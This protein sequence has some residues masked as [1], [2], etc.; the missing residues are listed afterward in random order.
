M[1]ASKSIVRENVGEEGVGSTVRRGLVGAAGGTAVEPD[2]RYVRRRPQVEPPVIGRHVGE[3]QGMGGDR[4][5][6]GRHGQAAQAAE[7][8]FAGSRL[9]PDDA[10]GPGR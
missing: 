1:T 10:E 4:V 5:V 7:R 6:D 8:R 9:A 3:N 2:A